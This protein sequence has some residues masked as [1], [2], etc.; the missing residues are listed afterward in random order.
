[1]ENRWGWSQTRRGKRS[2]KIKAQKE[3]TNQ[4]TESTQTRGHKGYTAIDQTQRHTERRTIE[5]GKGASS[6][7]KRGILREDTCLLT[8]HSAACA[9]G[10]TRTLDDT[11]YNK[12]LLSSYQILA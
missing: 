8:M 2:H 11:S 12:L 10:N 1:M 4:R 5:Q 7:K 9:Q 3:Y 6:K